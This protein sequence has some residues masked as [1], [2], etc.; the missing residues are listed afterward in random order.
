M[1]PVFSPAGQQF[2]PANGAPRPTLNRTAANQPPLGAWILFLYTFIAFSRVFDVVVP[3]L[4]V[5]IVLFGGIAVATLF[6]GRILQFLRTGVGRWLAAL[7][8]WVAIT[9][10]FST[11]RGGSAPFIVDALRSFVFAVSIIGLISQLPQVYR[12]LRVIAYS[13]LVGALLSFIYGQLSYGRL[14]L[15]QGTFGDPNQ[16]AMTLLFSLPFWILLAKNTSGVLKLIPFA[17]MAPI[18]VAFLRTGSRGAG[19]GFVAFCLALFWKTPSSRKV[20]LLLL[21]G[22]ALT[23][24][25]AFL[26]NYVRDRYMTFFSADSAVATNEAERE[27]IEG[28]D[29][30]S[31]EARLTLLISSIEM[32]LRYPIFGVGPGQFSYQVWLQRK[33]QGKGSLYNET[34]NTFTQVSSELGIPG[35]ILFIGVLITSIRDL[36]SVTKL[37]KSNSYKIPANV[38]DT[39]DALFVALVSLC[40]CGFFL[41]L[42]WGPLFFV[43]PAIIG[44]FTQAVQNS[45]PSWV[46]APAAASASLAHAGSFRPPLP[47]TTPSTP[48]AAPA[49]PAAL[50]GR[51]LG[52]RIFHNR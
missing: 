17:C 35:L 13:I 47:P 27:R 2:V 24:G 45:L 48:S 34:H 39:A 10:P 40:V 43:L 50:S 31:S 15:S 9:I 12:L 25:L 4:R 22:A 33:E 8:V 41:S 51:N 16:Y 26:P 52:R 42:I 37:K 29:I 32:T 11:W 1:S 3:G 23:I 5:A 21:L 44:A 19:I 30:G 28:A 36:R 14:V 18:F 7:T 20:P 49:R 46:I 38:L 6:S